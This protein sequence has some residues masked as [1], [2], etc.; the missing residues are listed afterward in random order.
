LSHDW[1]GVTAHLRYDADGLPEAL[2]RHVLD[3]LAIN[4]DNA[5]SRLIET[6]KEAKEGALARTAATDDGNLLA[7]RNGEG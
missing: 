2:Q 5:R 4:G 1:I 7:G 3:R 6:V